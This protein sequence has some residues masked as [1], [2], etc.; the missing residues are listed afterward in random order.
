MRRGD[1]LVYPPSRL[2]VFTC[3]S[4]FI[5]SIQCRQVQQPRATNLNANCATID[6]SCTAINSLRATINSSWAT[7]LNANCY[8]I[9]LSTSTWHRPYPTPTPGQED[10]REYREILRIHETCQRLKLS[11]FTIELLRLAGCFNSG[12]PAI[13]GLRIASITNYGTLYNIEPPMRLFSWFHLMSSKR[14]SREWPGGILT[15]T[16]ETVVPL[17]RDDITPAERL[18]QQFVIAKTLCHEIM[19]R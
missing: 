9:K 3:P 15:I 1:A 14:D 10:S 6:T 2:I 17:L 16:A 12:N 4:Y 5:I 11:G 19:V 7:N 13:L 18:A 8:S